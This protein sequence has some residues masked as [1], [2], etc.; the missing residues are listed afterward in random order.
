MK[1]LRYAKRLIS[2]P[3]V[4]SQTNQLPSKYVEIKLEKYGFTTE[5]LE[6]RDENNVKKVNI[7]AKRGMGEGGLAYFG[8]TDTVPADQWFSEQYS[9][10][11]P[12]V[13]KERLYGRGSCDM[14]GSV[15]CMLAAVQL[16]DLEE[17]EHPIYFCV[18][19]DEEVGYTGAR[20]VSEESQ[21]YREMV[22]GGTKTII[23]EPTMLQVVHAHK[24]TYG[25]RAKS[26]GKAAHSSTRYGLNANLAMIPFLQDMK[27]IHDETEVSVD[28]QN[29][30]FDPPT[31]SWNIGINDQ[32]SAVNMT[33]AQSVCTVYF[34]PMPGQNP[35]ILLDRVTR[36]A[37]KH[38]VQLE[39]SRCGE[40]VYTDP[41]S[42]FVQKSLRLANRSA[43]Q[44]VSYGT[45]GGALTE[46]EN[47]IVFGPGNIAQA[48]TE[49]EWIAI[50]QLNLGTQ[51]YA[52]F[53]RYFCC[54]GEEE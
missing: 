39:I 35:E 20:H 22:N 48:H 31:I 29:N 53:I 24:G 27:E 41:N 28:W 9:P 33:P 18:T 36:S 14:K 17:L 40:P 26:I 52:K 23:G 19:A 54:G 43:A 34:R 7:V 37:E 4:S 1:T 32:T 21:F 38:G 10:Y 30:E 6:Y 46:L 47:L 15:A 12:F 45:D 2:F 51:M 13:A 44:T 3:S 25:I 50:E 8:H 11:E 16:F 5:R 42:S 49:D